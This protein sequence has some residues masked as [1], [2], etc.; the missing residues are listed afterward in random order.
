MGGKKTDIIRFET[1]EGRSGQI[2]IAIV[3]GNNPGPEAVITAGIHGCEYCGVLAAI[4]LFCELS[5]SDIKG[6]VK[7]LTVSDTAAFET[8]TPAP[9]DDGLNLNRNFPGRS[10]GAYNSVLAA[11]IFDEIKGADYH[12]DLHC[13]GTHERSTQFAVCHRGRNGELND[14]SHE[15]AYY[16]GLPNIV[17]T[18]TNGGRW[19]DKGTCCA[20]VYETIGIPSVLLQSGGMGVVSAQSVNRQ[21]EGI[22]NIMR[23]FGTLRGALQPV[24][25]PQIFENMEIVRSKSGGIHY[26]RVN[27]GDSVKRGQAIGVITDWFGVPKEK[28]ISPVTGKILFMTEDASVPEK[29]FIAAIGVS[30]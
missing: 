22:K 19:S 14:L 7:I 26:R 24:G 17:I 30:R 12:I 21:A 8:R 11:K 27:A 4:K 25:R 28:I 1:E 6:C 9:T 13:G 2:P 18:E 15:M 16:S 10:K 23:R 29:G 20:S 3:A 5:P